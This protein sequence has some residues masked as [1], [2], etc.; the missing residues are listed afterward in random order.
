MRVFLLVI[1]SFLLGCA[2]PDTRAVAD[3]ARSLSAP[4]A[5]AP[6]TVLRAAVDSMDPS[7]AAVAHWRGSMTP[8]KIDTLMSAAFTAEG[9]LTSSEE[10]FGFLA[11]DPALV[12]IGKIPGSIPRLV[13]CLGWDQRA[14]ALLDDK[15]VLVGVIC[16]Q[17]ILRSSYGQRLANGGPWPANIDERSTITDFRRAQS[18]WLKILQTHPPE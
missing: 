13:E 1:T 14:H 16:S 18:D 4:S 6:H 15:R 9:G 2:K 12:Q 17:G 8:D 10:D 3:S 11:S 5:V 7:P